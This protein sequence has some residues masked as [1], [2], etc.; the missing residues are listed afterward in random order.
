MSS[1]QRMKDVLVQLRQA[2]FTGKFTMS[3]NG[4]GDSGDV[5]PPDYRDIAG[6]PQ[7]SLKGAIEALGVIDDYDSGDPTKISVYGVAGDVLPGGWEINEGSSGEIVFDI[8][9]CTITVC[10]NENVMSTEYTEYEA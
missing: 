7:P 1:K 9:K 2:G 10:N 6:K 5:E 8:D 3:Y 4:C